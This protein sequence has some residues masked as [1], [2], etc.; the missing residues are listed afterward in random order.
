MPSFYAQKFLQDLERTKAAVDGC[1][2]D[3]FN[4]AAAMKSV[5]ELV[6][7]T[8]SCLLNQ[9]AGGPMVGTMEIFLVRDYVL[10]LMHLLGME[11]SSLNEVCHGV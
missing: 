5:L 7:R 3:D 6:S 10:R 9:G 1:F 8:N 2:R 4:T 11:Y